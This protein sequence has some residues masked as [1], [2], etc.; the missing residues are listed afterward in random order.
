MNPYLETD[1]S[2]VRFIIVWFV[3]LSTLFCLNCVVRRPS[4]SSS[5]AF[6]FVVCYS[7][8]LLVQ[9][10]C[11]RKSQSRTTCLGGPVY[12][13]A[14][15]R[16]VNIFSQLFVSGN[17]GE[18]EPRFRSVSPS[19][20]VPG[21]Y[22]ALLAS[23]TRAGRTRILPA[24]LYLSSLSRACTWYLARF[25]LNWVKLGN[26]SCHCEN[27]MHTRRPNQNIMYTLR[28]SQYKQNWLL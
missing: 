27:I 15:I 3:S 5:F 8:Q 12:S 14:F 20:L 13:A 4:S 11:S 16:L 26:G 21:L 24:A 17:T 22:L 2:H 10:Y 9:F 28:H 25:F 19:L 18:R 1:R 6:V 23:T 7:T